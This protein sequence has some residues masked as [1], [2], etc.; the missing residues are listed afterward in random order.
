MYSTKALMPASGSLKAGDLVHSFD[1][2]MAIGI[3]DDHK[4]YY[5]YNLHY[6]W[7]TGFGFDRKGRKV[8]F[9]LTDNQVENQT[10][11]NENR[12]WLD[13]EIHPLA[14]VKITRPFGRTSPWNIQ[15]T[16]GMVDLVFTPEVSH[17]I[18]LNLGLAE[19]DYAGPFGRFEGR[20][21]SP[22]GELIVASGLYGMGEDK[23]MRI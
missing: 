21:R 1:P 15:D 4:G 5:P 22:S 6:D 9:N 8:G 17:D 7:V 10:K 2:S 14:P 12:L 23:R 13:D 16:E 18:A 19:V 11:Y 3:F 20:L